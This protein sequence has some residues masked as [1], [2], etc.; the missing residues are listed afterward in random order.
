MKEL[1]RSTD[2]EIESHHK[3]KEI[4][5]GH[6]EI[7][8]LRVIT[9][10]NRKLLMKIVEIS[11]G[12]QLIFDKDRRVKVSNRYAAESL[13]SARNQ[14]SLQSRGALSSR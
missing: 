12:K 8:S 3:M 9:N 11:H 2:Q 10:D 14:S 13:A 5:R 6:K 4:D 7:E 1:A